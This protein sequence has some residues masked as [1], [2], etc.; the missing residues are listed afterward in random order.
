MEYHGGMYKVDKCPGDLQNISDNNL[1]VCIKVGEKYR[2]S[3][4]STM[5][6]AQCAKIT[7]LL[8][9]NSSF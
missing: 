4:V 7:D 3:A 6:S 5:I 1:G 9:K 2:I 8:P